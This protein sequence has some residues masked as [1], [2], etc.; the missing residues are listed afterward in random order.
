MSAPWS[1]CESVILLSSEG[2]FW[3]SGTDT[4]CWSRTSIFICRIAGYLDVDEVLGECFPHPNYY[5]LHRKLCHED[6]PVEAKRCI[7]FG[8]QGHEVLGFGQVF[9]SVLGGPCDFNEWEKTILSVYRYSK[10]A[11]NLDS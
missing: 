8:E 2:V 10:S 4:I 11:F 9:T 3:M 6:L 1:N 5:I 7:D